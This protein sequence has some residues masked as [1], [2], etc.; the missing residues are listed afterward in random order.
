MKFPRLLVLAGI[1]CLFVTTT[2]AL[3]RDAFTF[4]KYDLNVRVEPEQQRLAV[5]GR[6]TLRNDSQAAQKNAELQISSSLEWRSIRVG[7]KSIQFVTQVYTSDIDHTG[8][9][10]E[11]VIT[12]PQEVKPGGEVELEVGYEGTVPLDTTRLTR[13]GTPED[14]AKHTDWDQVG[15]LFSAVRGVGYAVWYPVAMAAGNLSEGN[16][17]FEVLGKWKAKEA[18]SNMHMV[19][20]LFQT[21]SGTHQILLGNGDCI[22]AIT[23]GGTN[24]YQTTECSYSPLRFTV[25][26]F[27]VGAYGPAEGANLRVWAKPEHKSI[28]DKYLA[29]ADRTIPL[30]KDWFGNLQG[31]AV[32]I[33]LP[34]PQAAPFESGAVL[35]TQ[36][37]DD[38]KLAEISLVHELTHAAFH[39]SRPWIN[40]GAAHFAQALYREQQ[41]GRE[42]ALDYM[43][44]HASA[45]VQAEKTLRASGNNNSA[46]S[47]SLITTVDEELYRSKAMFVFWM[48]RDMIGNAEIKKALAAYRAE[49][50]NAPSYLQHLISA[51]TR[52]D[53]EWFFDDWVY[54]DR[55]LPDFR[56]ESA[57]P[58]KTV[59]G[60]Y[61]V[62]VTIENLGSA[63]AEVPVSVRVEGGEVTKRLEVRGGAKASI[64][65]EA[66]GRPLEVVVNDG[67]VP[68]TDLTNNSFKV[69]VQD[70]TN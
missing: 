13:I 30:V 55:G 22:Q 1:C 69:E 7:G 46:T 49:E 53:L 70:T 45:V 56:V 60:G 21:Q 14:V 59:L 4:T 25:P 47:A 17:L 5:R 64:R 8:A 34:E 39:S 15:Q 68:E 12:L 23:E 62:T 43:G 66:P 67:S 50:D 63:G 10:S 65:I 19:L 35:L 38:T 58:R 48:L 27:V 3:D 52:R 33:E 42:A 57:Y 11:A 54:R 61:I 26:A 18:V 36:L 6:I 51:Q 32:V 44:L 20:D 9:L 40:E 29:A 41:A 2:F 37:S 16:S 28:A 24:E 31:K